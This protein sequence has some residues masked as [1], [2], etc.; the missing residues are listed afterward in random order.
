MVKVKLQKEFMGRLWKIHEALLY[1]RD[2]DPRT[3]WIRVYL[4]T[5]LQM[6]LTVEDTRNVIR[7]AQGLRAHTESNTFFT[8]EE[9][10]EDLK[11]HQ[12]ATLAHR[13]AT[14]KQRG[15]DRGADKKGDGRTPRDP[16]K[17][18]TRK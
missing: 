12:A 5:T 9:D 11:E 7:E 6:T 14:P 1:N 16:R 8:T 15:Y 3:T 17:S 18:S 4:A 13:A 10:K 2:T